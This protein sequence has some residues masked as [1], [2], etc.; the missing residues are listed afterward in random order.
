MLFISVFRN[1]DVPLPSASERP[2]QGLLTSG[3]KAFLKPVRLLGAKALPGTQLTTTGRPPSQLPLD[4][5]A[6]SWPSRQ[7]DRW[8]SFPVQLTE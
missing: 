4:L 3:L 5:S 6:T 7:L 8:A 2:L 1:P